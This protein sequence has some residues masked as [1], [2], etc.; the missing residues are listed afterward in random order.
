MTMSMKARTP[1]AIVIVFAFGFVLTLQ[2]QTLRNLRIENDALRADINVMSLLAREND[3]LS[4]RVVQ[5]SLIEPN[6]G[7]LA[8]LRGEV[9]RLRE[10][11]A[12]LL[13]AASISNDR[14]AP[15]E[16]ASDIA[17]HKLRFAEA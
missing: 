13:R 10:E 15:I 16:L 8:R 7:E 2:Y 4:N 5:A 17:Q 11:N 1:I 12:N 9:T 14:K 3:R 6:L